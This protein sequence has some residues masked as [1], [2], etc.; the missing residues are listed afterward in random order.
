MLAPLRRCSYNRR[1]YILPVTD[2]SD[3]GG[4]SGGG[5]GGVGD[6]IILYDRLVKKYGILHDYN[7]QGLLWKVYD[8]F[9]TF[10]QPRNKSWPTAMF[11]EQNPCFLPYNW[12][13]RIIYSC[14][15]LVTNVWIRL[16]CKPVCVH[17]AAKMPFQLGLL[18]TKE[19]PRTMILVISVF[20]DSSSKSNRSYASKQC[21]PDTPTGQK[22]LVSNALPQT[23]MVGGQT[24]CTS[25]PLFGIRL[26]PSS[27]F[28]GKV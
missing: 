15:I 24:H 22:L 3:G 1:A 23:H 21:I 5:G 20:L 27:H 8:H 10:H 18:L 26:S 9:H 6:S 28:V 16:N 13:Y 19:E 14:T 25:V 11:M 7:C 17:K 4:N 2:Y 12:L